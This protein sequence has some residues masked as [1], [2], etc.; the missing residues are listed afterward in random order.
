VISGD[1]GNEN[2]INGVRYDHVMPVEV[3]TPV[4]LQNL[5]VKCFNGERAHSLPRGGLW[6]GTSCICVNSV[7]QRIAS[8]NAAVS[9]PLAR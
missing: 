7:K 2:V 5:R 3:E 6:T 4:G 9:L 1:E 8:D